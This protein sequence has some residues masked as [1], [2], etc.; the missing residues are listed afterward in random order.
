S[1][2]LKE[3]C[4]AW[5]SITRSLYNTRLSVLQHGQKAHYSY[6]T[7]IRIAMAQH[8]C[9]SAPRKSIHRLGASSSNHVD[10]KS[11]MTI[12]TAEIPNSFLDKLAHP[13]R[14]PPL[15]AAF[16]V[17]ARKVEYE[18]YT[19]FQQRISQALMP[20]GTKRARDPNSHNDHHGHHA[21][22]RRRADNG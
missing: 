12:Y 8:Q 9:C 17:Q 15:S 21:Q 10:N 18:P 13:C 4:Q 7:A 3:S 19:T 16:Q 2:Y 11:R 1:K 22:K 14:R 20:C 5:N 6:I